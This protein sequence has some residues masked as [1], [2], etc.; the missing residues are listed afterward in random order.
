MYGEE[1]KDGETVT[2][3]IDLLYVDQVGT[4]VLSLLNK[5]P[6]L[7]ER[8]QVCCFVLTCTPPIVLQ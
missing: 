7:P 4:H 3:L 8:P 6:N 2:G 5:V 1:E